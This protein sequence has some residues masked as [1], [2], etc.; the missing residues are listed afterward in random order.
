MSDQKSRADSVS[1]ENGVLFAHDLDDHQ[2]IEIEGATIH[3]G[4]HPIYGN[5]FI[6]IP[7]FGE[8]VM[9]HPF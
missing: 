1:F 7:A 5:I 8:A 6:V 9:L 2:C 4:I 3:S